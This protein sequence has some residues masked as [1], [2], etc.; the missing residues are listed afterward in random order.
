MLSVLSVSKK[1]E[2]LGFEKGPWSFPGSKGIYLVIEHKATLPKN[3]LNSHVYKKQLESEI[4][5][6]QIHFLFPVS[7]KWHHRE[8]AKWLQGPGGPLK[9]GCVCSSGSKGSL[10]RGEGSREV[11]SCRARAELEEPGRNLPEQFWTDQL[12]QKKARGSQG[13][14]GHRLRLP[15]AG[16]W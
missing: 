11:K 6:K 8:E 9:M 5:Q 1:S 16:L 7:A 12:G 14:S 15:S 10:Q 2:N 13:P 4:I 3:Q